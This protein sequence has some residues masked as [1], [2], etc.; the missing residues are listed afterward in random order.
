LN[1]NGTY[2]ANG[3]ANFINTASSLKDA[4]NKLDAQIKLNADDI[5]SID[6]RT[7]TLESNAA[8]VRASILAARDGGVWSQEG[9]EVI[10]APD[11]FIIRQTYG[12]WAYSPSTNDFIFIA[13]I[14]G[15]GDRHWEYD[16]A[17]PG[18]LIF[19]GVV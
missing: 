7:T 9:D 18:N 19:T 17:N 8:V 6:S 11:S 12:A 5:S 16:T 1:A 14:G 13:P 4:D 2:S 3:A 10:Y 15:A